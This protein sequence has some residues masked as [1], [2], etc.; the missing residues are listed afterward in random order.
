MGM[1][2]SS[3][4]KLSEKMDKKNEESYAGRA[5]DRTADAEFTHARLEGSA[6]HAEDNGCAFGSSDAPSGLPERAQNV[7]ALGVF[8]R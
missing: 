8:E 3:R 5:L 2:S 7:L 1:Y 6:L 4:R